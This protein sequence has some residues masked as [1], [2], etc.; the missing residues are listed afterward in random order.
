[1]RR[2]RPGRNSIERNKIGDLKSMQEK[3]LQKYI[4]L[5]MKA[6]MDDKKEL[7][8]AAKE[9]NKTVVE[10]LVDRVVAVVAK[11]SGF[12]S[13]EIAYKMLFSHAFY[14][15]LDYKLILKEKQEE[16]VQHEK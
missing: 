6:M 13:Y 14:E 12:S 11:K 7:E 2:K 3:E 9:E 4:F 15:Y 16:A 8:S 1:M 10:M 5:A